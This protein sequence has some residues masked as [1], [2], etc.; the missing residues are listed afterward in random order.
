M[1]LQEVGRGTMDWLADVQIRYRFAAMENVVMNL[2][3][4]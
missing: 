1:Y 3:V 2:R 4:P